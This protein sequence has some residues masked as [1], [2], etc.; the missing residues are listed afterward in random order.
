MDWFVLAIAIATF[1]VLMARPFGLDEA[2][3]A[4]A[5]AC[6][7][8]TAGAIGLA[9]VMAVI[10]ET[11]D[12][13]L[14]LFGMMLVTCLAEQAGVFDR[15][16]S[17]VTRLAG[18][19]G[20]A[21]YVLIFLLGAATTTF[22]S[23]DAT[24]L[25][26]TPIVYAVAVRHRLDALPFMFACTFVANTGSLFLP[27][28]NLT[29]LLVYSQLD[30]E[31]GAFARTMVLP[32]LAAVVTNLA[33]FLWIFRDRLPRTID[34]AVAHERRGDWWEKAA[35]IVLGLTLLGILAAG[36][37][38]VALAAPALV[39]G[40][41]LLAI[42]LIGRRIQLRAVIDGV[43]WQLFVFIIGMF[44]LVRAV[45]HQW[46]T[47]LVAPVPTSML[48]A[49][50]VVVIGSAVG[51]NLVNNVPMALVAISMIPS[52][53]GQPRDILAYSTLI[54]TNIGP[55]LTTY[56]SL[57]TMLWLVIVRKR[58]ID[59]ST[60]EYLKVAFLTAPPTLLAA[61]LTLWL[62]MR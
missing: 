40:G 5:G 60:R 43:S 8:V 9:D 42:G 16:A 15:L 32:D 51:S 48:L 29:N 21:L 59:V 46:L 22:L 25:V 7:V 33:V 1:A 52:M 50:A 35:M 56:G 3:V 45:E 4:A 11:S 57:A 24:V 53:A 34:V 12:V 47:R 23:L 14:F 27:I 6:V 10:R 41:A 2:W 13:V 49:M 20:R 31:F 30:L 38:H 26:L 39:G 62:V 28:S 36:L 17:G 44:V 37:F 61:T 55:T 58:G 19:S 54:G 18:G